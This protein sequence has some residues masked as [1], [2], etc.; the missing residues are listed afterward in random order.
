MTN[1]SKNQLHIKVPSK[2]SIIK[3]VPIDVQN[4]ES[5][6]FSSLIV[7]PGYESIGVLCIVPYHFGGHWVQ[8]D[9]HN[10]PANIMSLTLYKRD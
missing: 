4:V 10:I 8:I 1:G 5:N 3:V 2:L 7:G 6:I 9:V